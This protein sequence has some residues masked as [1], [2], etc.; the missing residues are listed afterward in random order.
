[1]SKWNR[2][3]I[4]VILSLSSYIAYSQINCT[5]PLAPVLNYVSV[6]P[7][8]GNTI[9]DWTL[10]QSTDIAAYILYT[11]EDGD[12]MAFD[13]IWDPAVH[14][15]TINNTASK[16]SSFSYVVAAYRL[17]VIPGMDGCPSPLSN[18]LTTIF[19]QSVI[20]TCNKKIVLSW[21][22]YPSFPHPVTDYSILLSVNGES[23]IEIDKVNPD[24][25]NFILNDF[26]VDED[27]CFVIR[28]N[29]EG[30]LFS[31]SNKTCLLTK[32]QRAPQWINADDANVTEEN[33]VSLSFTIDPMTEIFH[34]SLERRTGYEGNFQEIAQPVSA[35][36][37]VLFTDN[38]ADINTVNF[39]RL[40]ALNNCNIPVT[41]SNLSSNMVL[42]LERI[43]NDLN[44]SWN[45][46]KEWNGT[47]F[48]YR[49]FINTGNGFEERA[50]LQ[51]SDTVITLG[52]NELM[53]QVT[54][55]EICFYI[56]A[57]EISNPNG[58]NGQSLS[59]HVCTVPT[60][61]VTVPNV[62]TPNNDLVND[63]FRP[64]LSF[65]PVDYH[66]IISDRR[67]NTLFET[68]DYTA[69]WDGS[70]NGNNHPESVCLWFLKVVTPSGKSISKTGT[71][72]IINK[73]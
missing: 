66:L 9:L 60:E 51:P 3:I 37:S 47:I 8:T 44:L 59:S 68:R 41:Y 49:L 62:F 45:S 67:G 1:M 72:T 36:G 64:V 31:T 24:L 13:T 20:D 22:R 46:Y 12:G 56:L 2:N 21:N 42:V 57:S 7:E 6:E 43:G 18:V 27:Y 14:N 4:T 70:H 55:N 58:I 11:Y 39:Y 35:N 30:G 32:M 50:V 73:R 54:G 69:E 10:S 25:D 19:A 17:P 61:I 5:V 28:A 40:S 53:Y 29:L 71:V 16:Y 26:T 15:F 63:F 65:T 23:F 48:S 34:Y 38:K 52:Y 33:E